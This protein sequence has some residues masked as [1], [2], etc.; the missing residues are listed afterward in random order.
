[1]GTKLYCENLY[2]A[3]AEVMR[4]VPIRAG[5]SPERIAMLAK[6][7]IKPPQETH[8]DVAS[9]FCKALIPWPLGGWKDCYVS[10]EHFLHPSTFCV[11][12]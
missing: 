1:M 6:K 11:Q 5:S 3:L 7:P 9:L 10:A 12:G 8:A 4:H 2:L